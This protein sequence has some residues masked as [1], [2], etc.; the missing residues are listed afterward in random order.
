M[1]ISLFMTNICTPKPITY[2]TI[3]LV[4]IVLVIGSL[5]AFYFQSNVKK[6]SVHL[7]WKYK[8]G[9]TVFSTPQIYKGRVYFG[10]SDNYLY[11]LNASNS[12]LIWRFKTDNH[13]VSNPCI[14]ND[15][16]Y[17]TSFDTYLYA[18]NASTGEILWK[19]KSQYF[20]ESSPTVYKEVIYFGSNDNHVYA[21]NALTGE[22]KW[23]YFATSPL[24]LEGASS[25]FVSASPSIYEGI[26]YIGSY[27]DG[28]IFVNNT[29][30]EKGGG[31]MHALNAT[32]GELI[33]RF[34]AGGLVEPRYPQMYNGILYFGSWDHNIYAVNAKTG[35]KVWSYLTNGS[36]TQSAP[37]VYDNMVCVGS[38]DSYIYALDAKTGEKVWSYKAAGPIQS[39]LS[40]DHG[41]LYIGSAVAVGEIRGI[42]DIILDKGY[43]YAIDVKTGNQLWNYTTGGIVNSG[44]NFYSGVVYVGCGDGNVYALKVESGRT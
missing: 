36:I 37:R 24:S 26:V 28:Y 6:E 27:Y 40:I 13:I 11:A 19:F 44:P 1:V 2:I 22:L 16:I 25:G 17:L 12:G 42:A 4:L 31:C 34:D 7:L 35:E 21:L 8:T 9:G 10:S 32:T 20:I 18:L 43:V 23:S 5:L 39:P 29:P 3:A 14:W 30:I 33:W 38:F 41:V 15:R